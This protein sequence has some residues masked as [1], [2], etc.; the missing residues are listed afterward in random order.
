TFGGVLDATTLAALHAAV[1][2]NG[3][4]APLQAALDNLS[5][6]NHRQG[7]PYFTPYPELLPLSLAYANSTD[8]VQTRCATPLQSF[9]PSP[10]SKRKE[11]QA[12]AAVTSAADVDAS[13]AAKLLQDA[14]VLHAA[15]KS[16]GAAISDLTALESSG[17]SAQFFLTNNPG[18]QADLTVDAV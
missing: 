17:L 2:A 18:A 5:T 11:Q 12:L 9:L 10:K 4:Y 6:V 14:D 16:A 7:D 3:N 8:P 15:G 13:Y 1:T